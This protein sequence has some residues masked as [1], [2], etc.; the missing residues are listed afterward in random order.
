MILYKSNLTHISL[1]FLWASKLKHQKHSQV[2]ETIFL[3]QHLQILDYIQILIKIPY[4]ECICK[5]GF[6]T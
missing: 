1:Y 6:K 4:C 3:F 5:Y 2:H